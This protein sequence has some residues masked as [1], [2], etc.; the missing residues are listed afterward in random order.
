MKLTI[1][2]YFGSLVI[3]GLVLNCSKISEKVEQKV[4]EKVNEKMMKQILSRE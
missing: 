4:N 1:L 2:K 3:L